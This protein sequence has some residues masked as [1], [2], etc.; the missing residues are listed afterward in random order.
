MFILHAEKNRLWVRQRETVTSG[1]VGVY[2]VRFQFSPEWEGLGR[3]ACF[4]SGGQVVSV[5]LDGRNE[6]TVPWEVIGPDCK[7]KRLY[8]GVYGSRDGSVVLPTVWAD[9]GAVL[10]GAACGADARPPTPELWRQE[11]A[12]KADGLA[13]DGLELSLM[14]GDRPLA[15]VQIAGGGGEGTADHRTL[16]HRDAVGQHPISAIA[17][18]ERELSRRI[19]SGDALSVVDIIKIMEG[20]DHGR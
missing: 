13:Y 17:G 3:T 12:A 20:Q 8:A 19:Q 5:L 14:A 11:L 1:S 9:L 18:L 16:A 15:T 2:P 6:C 7:G 4:R 10:E